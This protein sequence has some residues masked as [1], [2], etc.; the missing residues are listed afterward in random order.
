MRARIGAA[1][2]ALVII[3]VAATGYVIGWQHL[4][5]LARN[6][7]ASSAGETFEDIARYIGDVSPPSGPFDV[8]ASVTQV[9]HWRL[10]NRA[11]EPFTAAGPRE[12]ARAL[13]TLVPDRSTPTAPLHI[14]LDAGTLF[15]HAQ[16]LRELPS[17]AVLSVLIDDRHFAVA[18]PDA[19]SERAMVAIRP[20]LLVDVAARDT[21]LEVLRQ[22][23][24]PLARSKVRMIA[25]EPGGA[26]LLMR[27]PTV[28][29][30]ARHPRPDI[31][32][33]EYLGSALGGLSGQ[34]LL[35]SGRLEQGNLIYKPGSG[36][37]GEIA[38][39]A[40]KTSVRSSD[41]SLVLL[42]ASSARQ[43]GTR[44]WLWQRIALSSVE[45][46][47]GGATLGEFLRA[48]AGEPGTL[49]VRA[50]GPSDDRIDLLVEPSVDDPVAPVARLTQ[51]VS[52]TW[53]NIVTETAGSVSVR[54]LRASMLTVAR[55]NELDRRIVPG[56]PYAAQMSYLGLIVVGLL[57]FPTVAAWWRRVWP[58]ETAADYPGRT[59]LVLAHAVRGL[60]LV[61]IFL[62]L[63]GPLALL[64]HLS[65]IGHTSSA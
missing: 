30:G 43:P 15:G 34:T 19:V 64:V 21:F 27:T 22:L 20:G 23:E 41:I 6:G 18:R 12:L 39:D 40:L 4:A 26:T 58:R 51:V 24:R 55:Q 31:I 56:I 54:A 10:A 9:G 60:A 45:K 53:S 1:A 65:R 46:A 62:P 7:N 17:D 63:V 13:A 48:L 2:I 35:L 8:A 38:M 3:A 28:D 25:L 52:G 59:G 33:P 36:P 32:D 37:A 44:N 49:V 16:S 50:V 61:L 57:A 5:T 11:G 47:L 14:L 29:P 42:D